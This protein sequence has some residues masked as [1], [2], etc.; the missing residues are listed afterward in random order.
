M[1]RR[2]IAL[3]ALI[4]FALSGLGLTAYASSAVKESPSVSAPC[5]EMAQADQA[6]HK[7]PAQ[8][9]DCESLGCHCALSHTPATLTPP[10]ALEL[11]APQAMR[12]YLTI[13]P[14]WALEVALTDP[15][16]RPPRA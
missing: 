3:F 2:L 16:K 9:K 8:H 10:L 11:A 4:A 12:A 14:A 1:S 7:T 15:L 6:E 5:H 13:A